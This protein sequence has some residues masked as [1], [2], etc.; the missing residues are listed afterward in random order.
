MNTK[1]TYKSFPLSENTSFEI[2]TNITEFDDK[3]VNVQK[4]CFTSRDHQQELTLNQLIVLN[5]ILEDIIKEMR[6]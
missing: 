6:S 3:S 1:T 5:Y 2:Q 4:R